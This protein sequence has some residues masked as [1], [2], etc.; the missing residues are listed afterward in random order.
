MDSEESRWVRV[1]SLPRRRTSGLRA[2][3]R[4]FTMMAAAFQSRG[5]VRIPTLDVLK[6]GSNL[7][8]RRV[9]ARYFS[10]QLIS[11][12]FWM[13]HRTKKSARLYRI[14]TRRLRSHS[15]AISMT[16]CLLMLARLVV[17]CYSLCLLS[18]AMLA[19]YS[20]FARK[21]EAVL[22]SLGCQMR[23]EEACGMTPKHSLEHSMPAMSTIDQLFE[24]LL[25]TQRPLA[26]VSWLLCLY[27]LGC[28]SGRL[29]LPCRVGR[30]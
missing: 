17:S 15:T 27:T 11:H 12:N 30:I 2:G 22:A 9:K 21:V 10:T 16:M 19:L 28:F 18:T 7:L 3:G 20:A 8:H 14:H 4:R 13:A 29:P 5:T 1:P 23:L 26:D 25:Y 6:K 24:V